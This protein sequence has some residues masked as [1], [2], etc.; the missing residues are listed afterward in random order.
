MTREVLAG[1]ATAVSIK[2][3][4]TGFTQSQR[5]HHLAEGLGLEVVMGNQIDGQLGTA[6]TIAFGAAYQLTSRRAGELSNFLDMSDDLLAEPLQIRDGVLCVAT[7]G[8]R[9][10]RD[11]RRQA[12]PLPH[13]PLTHASPVSKSGSLSQS[14]HRRGGQCV[15]R[16]PAIRRR[17][18]RRPDER[19]VLFL[20]LVQRQRPLR[21]DALNPWDPALTP[22]GSS[23]GAAA[24]VAVG[25]GA[26]AHRDRHR[27][28]D[29][30]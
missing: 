23:G 30:R 19:A 21:P 2:T 15:D 27:R 11:R 20:P 6:C 16:E 22:G 9:R 29:A 10:R 3:A 7:R 1:S 18:H 25:I 13:R 14:E 5:V 26:I 24:A 4:R 28:L 12:R 8:G 17:D